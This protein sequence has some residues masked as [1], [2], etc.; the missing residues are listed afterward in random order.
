MILSCVGP[1]FAV[2]CFLYDWYCA[3]VLL[4]DLLHGDVLRYSRDGE[5]GY[6]IET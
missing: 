1:S 4:H 5:L 3:G 2:R 6:M